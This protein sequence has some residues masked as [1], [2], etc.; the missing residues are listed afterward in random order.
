MG[1][2]SDDFSVG[3]PA[4][5]IVGVVGLEVFGDSPSRKVCFDGNSASIHMSAAEKE[6]SRNFVLMARRRRRKSTGVIG[7]VY[8]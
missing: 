7:F 2:D 3:N 5:K 4:G 1:S 8:Q 6:V